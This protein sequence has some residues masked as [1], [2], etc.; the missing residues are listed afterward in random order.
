MV[1]WVVIVPIK[2]F[3]DAKRRLEGVGDR[4][5]VAEALTR[6]TLEAVA[7]SSKVRMVLVMT[8]DPHLVEDL[9]LPVAAVVR[10]QQRAGLNGAVADGLAYA[11]ESW[12]EFA[13]AVLQGDLPALTPEDLDAVL[14]AAEELPLGMVPDADGRGTAMIT[15]APGMPLLPA[16][17]EGSAARHQE[18]GHKPIRASERL[19]RD[20]DTRAD[21]SAAVRLGVGRHTAEVLGLPVPVAPESAA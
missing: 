18:L 20:V 1:D 21:L 8:D 9:R 12:P 2:R 19:R 6:D 15:G 3:A 5:A 14:V 4:A 17:G 13:V 10:T 7:S 16:F 11:G